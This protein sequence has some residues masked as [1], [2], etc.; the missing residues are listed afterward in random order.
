MEINKRPRQYKGKCVNMFLRA[1]NI[2][3]PADFINTI[4]LEKNIILCSPS[5]LNIIKQNIDGS[6]SLNLLRDE[7]L[8]MG[9]TRSSGALCIFDYL[10]Y[11]KMCIPQGI[12]VNIDDPSFGSCFFEKTYT[13]S[14]MFYESDKTDDSRDKGFIELPPYVMLTNIKMTLHID[15]KRLRELNSSFLLKMG[16]PIANIF[17]TEM[18]HFKEFGKTL[19]KIIYI[20]DDEIYETFLNVL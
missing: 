4:N 9:K 20:R 19:D 14:D 12:K 13:H 17:F 5:R 3:D 2:D 16:Q 6:F 15:L 11:I 1:Q 8:S 10:P 18:P 7:N